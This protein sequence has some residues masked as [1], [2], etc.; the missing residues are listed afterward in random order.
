M[1]YE[2]A[3]PLTSYIVGKL[4]GLLLMIAAL[5]CCVRGDSD[6]C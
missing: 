4:K 6:V 5:Q 2:M 3:S 1:S